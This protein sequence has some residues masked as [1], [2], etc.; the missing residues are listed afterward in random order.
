MHVCRFQDE[1]IAYVHDKDLLAKL[2]SYSLR[3]QALNWYFHLLESSIDRYKDLIKVFLH[4]YGYNITEKV[5]LKDFCKIK[6]LPLQSITN[7]IRMW[8]QIVNKLTLEEQEL[9]HIFVDSLLTQ[10]KLFVISNHDLSL[11]VMINVVKKKENYIKKLYAMK[12]IDPMPSLPYI[13]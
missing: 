7:F 13:T 10:Y 1:A 11:R 8:T 5:Y 2:F 4:N 12:N 9:K 3:D 6:Q